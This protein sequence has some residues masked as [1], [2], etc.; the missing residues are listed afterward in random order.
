MVTY[1]EMRAFLNAKRDECHAQVATI[2]TVLTALDQLAP[3]PLVAEAPIALQTKRGRPPTQQ[4]AED[5]PSRNV[6][7]A[8]V[9]KVEVYREAILKY[10]SSFTLVPHHA[11]DTVVLQ[12]EV[13]KACKVDPKKDETFTKDLANAVQ[14][15]KGKGLIE[16]SGTMWALT[17]KPEDRS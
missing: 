4:R 5:Q 14:S 7:T 17:T 9:S 3:M 10:L 8:G 16:R 12:R 15:L 2:D 13:S 1:H 6:T 11:A